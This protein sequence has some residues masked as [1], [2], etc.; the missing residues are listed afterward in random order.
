MIQPTSAIDLINATRGHPPSELQEKFS[1]DQM[2][3]ALHL[4][5]HWHK[6]DMERRDKRS[7]RHYQMLQVCAGKYAILKLE[8]NALRKKLYPKQYE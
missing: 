7:S 5:H 4:L 1:P 8:N 6:G 3:T 2:A